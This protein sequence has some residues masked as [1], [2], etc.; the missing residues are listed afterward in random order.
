MGFFF[1]FVVLLS[2]GTKFANISEGTAILHIGLSQF[3]L[4]F[5]FLLQNGSAI[6]LNLIYLQVPSFV[7]LLYK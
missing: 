5:L 2:Q 1:V 6:W 4:L 7:K 3:G